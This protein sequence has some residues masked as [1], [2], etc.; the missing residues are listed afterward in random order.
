MQGN[1]KSLFVEL[2][3]E[4]KSKTSTNLKTKGRGCMDFQPILSILSAKMAGV[5]LLTGQLAIQGLCA[6][7]RHTNGLFCYP[8]KEDSNEP[9]SKG[10]FP[11][12]NL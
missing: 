3:D 5:D 8:G 2:L 10:I 6:Y 12:I 9:Q 11:C 1:T 7:G 4:S